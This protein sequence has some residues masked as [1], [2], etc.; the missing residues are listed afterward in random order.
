VSD[1]IM[2]AGGWM[3][4]VMFWVMTHAEASAGILAGAAVAFAVLRAALARIRAG[5]AQLARGIY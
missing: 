3:F 5:S 4:M 1:A 2:A